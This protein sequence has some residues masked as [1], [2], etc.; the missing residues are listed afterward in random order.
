MNENEIS[1]LKNKTIEE[2]EVKKKEADKS[3]ETAQTFLAV[4]LG[5]VI[6]PLGIYFLAKKIFG[7]KKQELTS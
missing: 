3:N 4:I 2:T 6:F 1:S 7:K 5:I